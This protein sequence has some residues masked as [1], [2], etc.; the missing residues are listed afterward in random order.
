MDRAL[1]VKCRLIIVGGQATIDILSPK[2]TAREFIS[3]YLDLGKVRFLR[4][5]IRF[6]VI[7]RFGKRN[8]GLKTPDHDVT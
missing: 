5:H 8:P 2:L 6:S 4:R 1:H 7:I 3:P